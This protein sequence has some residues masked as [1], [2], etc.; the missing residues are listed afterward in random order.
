MEI[1]KA[2]AGDLPNAIFV[3]VGGGGLISGVAA[4]VK[5]VAPS[6]RIIGVEPEG[7]NL[8]EASLHA[9]ERVSFSVVNRFTDD[10]GVRVMGKENFRLCKELVDDVVQVTTDEICS[11]IKDVFGDTRSLMEP[12]GA[13]SVAGAKKYAKQN[14]VEN[15]VYVAVLAAAN[16]DFDRLRFVSERSDDR[17]RFMSVKIPEL[18]GSFQRLYHL[19]C[20]WKEK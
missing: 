8:L 11:A 14:P 16:M 3:P 4:Y 13:I 5:E 9:N 17:E 6:V 19:I 15:Q 2:T 12:L 18:K 10:V 20:T 1:L 7:A